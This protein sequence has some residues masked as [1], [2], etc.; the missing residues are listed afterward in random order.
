VDRSDDGLRRSQEKIDEARE[1]VDRAREK[2][3]PVPTRER[4]EAERVDGD[5]AR[6]AGSLM[7]EGEGLAR[8]E[9]DLRKGERDTPPA[10]GEE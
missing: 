4:E 6:P 2:E 7:G 8:L 5:D 1:A 3:S 10:D 9:S